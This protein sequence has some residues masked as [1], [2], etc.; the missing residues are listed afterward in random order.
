MNDVIALEN[1]GN[2]LGPI[3]A[4]TIDE[5]QGDSIIAN[6]AAL[7]GN[8]LLTKETLIKTSNDLIRGEPLVAQYPQLL[9]FAQQAAALIRVLATQ[10][11]AFNGP[12]AAV[13]ALTEVLAEQ[14]LVNTP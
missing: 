14:T 10:F 13:P 3:A 7:R 2:A 1:L 4:P 11:N 12:Y 9:R 8:P 6:A 5:L